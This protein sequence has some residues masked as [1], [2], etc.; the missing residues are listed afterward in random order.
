MTNKQ[1][2]LSKQ[3]VTKAYKEALKA[4]S[5]ARGAIPDQTRQSMAEAVHEF[6]RL[7]EERIESKQ[8]DHLTHSA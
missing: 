3:D 2:V 5:M 8:A 6:H 1:P 7:L 4:V